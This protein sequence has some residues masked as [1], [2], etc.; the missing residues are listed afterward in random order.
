MLGMKN[1]TRSV[2]EETVPDIKTAEPAVSN[3]ELRSYLSNAR[4]EFTDATVSYLPI[5]D[6]LLDTIAFNNAPPYLGEY[7][8]GANIESSVSKVLNIVHG[9]GYNGKIAIDNP[10]QEVIPSKV[11]VEVTLL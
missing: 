5:L 7:S 4:L 1:K 9:K 6:W 8:E 10:V 2:P 11:N 3:K